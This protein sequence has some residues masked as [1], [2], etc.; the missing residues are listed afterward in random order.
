MLMVARVINTSRARAAPTRSIIISTTGL[1]TL[2]RR[3]NEYRNIDGLSTRGATTSDRTGG[4][5]ICNESLGG[6]EF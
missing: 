2:R 5:R 1:E 4:G 6:Y 3:A